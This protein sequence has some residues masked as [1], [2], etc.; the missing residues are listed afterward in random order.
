MSRRDRNRRITGM[1]HG[2]SVYLSRTE[3]MV[4][5]AATVVRCTTQIRGLH[6]QR[7]TPRMRSGIRGVSA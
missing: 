2:A 5:V 1:Q 7:E 6:D 3:I 4:T